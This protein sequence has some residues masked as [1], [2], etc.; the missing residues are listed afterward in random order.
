[1]WRDVE[2]GGMGGA[3]R[4]EADGRCDEMGKWGDEE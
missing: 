4:C 3:K 1:M 2:V